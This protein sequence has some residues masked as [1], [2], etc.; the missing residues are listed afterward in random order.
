[1]IN[2]ATAVAL[3]FFV[4]YLIF[5]ALI[6]IPTLTTFLFVQI[7]LE[8]PVMP[9]WAVALVVLLATVLLVVISTGLIWKTAESLMKT[10]DGSVSES[11]PVDLDKIFR[12][13]LSVIGIFYT[14]QALI[15]LPRQ[16]G[17]FQ[18]VREQQMALQ[19][20]PALVSTA[21]QLLLGLWLIAKPRQWAEWLQKLGD[22]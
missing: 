11:H 5:S 12:L 18:M 19:A 22:R 13:A 1:M 3:K 15:G 10:G 2:K 4:F 20:T 7:P 8:N 16:W 6:S 9:T 21:L 14:F 17:Y